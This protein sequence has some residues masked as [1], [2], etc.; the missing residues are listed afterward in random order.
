[1]Y[2]REIRR[3]PFYDSTFHHFLS[4]IPSVKTT[5]S[6]RQSHCI[7][8][9]IGIPIYNPFNICLHILRKIDSVVDML[10]TTIATFSFMHQDKLVMLKINIF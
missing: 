10:C 3:N 5:N 2:F 8:L 6:H 9:F 1:M 4:N 7:D